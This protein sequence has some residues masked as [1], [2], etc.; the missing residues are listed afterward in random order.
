MCGVSIVFN[1]S[2]ALLKS[3]K[4]VYLTFKS[5][6]KSTLECS[7]V[8]QYSNTGTRCVNFKDDFS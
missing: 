2:I 4:N 6:R 1:V 8:N 3:Q 5:L 7:D